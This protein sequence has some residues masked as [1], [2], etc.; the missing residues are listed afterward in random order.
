M[1]QK[2]PRVHIFQIDEQ[3]NSQSTHLSD[4]RAR[5]YSVDASFRLMCWKIQM[6]SKVPS[7]HYGQIC[8]EIP[9]PHIF[10]ID[11][12]G[13]TQSRNLQASCAGKHPDYTSLRQVCR[14]TPRVHI[15]KVDVQGNSLITHLSDRCSGKHPEYTSSR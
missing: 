3:G 15:F 14:E 5:K 4:R 12:Q 6:Y 2:I 11:V 13:N 10:Q 8:S 9:R 7:I 1:C